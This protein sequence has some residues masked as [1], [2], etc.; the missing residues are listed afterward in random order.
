[1]LNKLTK[2][3]KSFALLLS[4]ELWERW[5]YYGMQALL[6]LYFVKHLGYSDKTAYA[7][8]A[9]F[10]ALLY[11]F[12]S[13]GGF[14]CD[15]LIGAK[16]TL[17]LGASILC[18]GYGF[19]AF[20][21]THE[22]FFPLAVIVVGGGVFKP[23]PSRLIS[24]L[25]EKNSGQ[26]S[27]AFTLFYMSVNVGSLLSMAVTPMVAKYYGFHAAFAVSFVGMFAAV[28]NYIFMRKLLSHIT[29]KAGQR[30]LTL[31]K[32]YI[33]CT[34]LVGSIAISYWLL[35]HYEITG[36]TIL[37]AGIAILIYL[38]KESAHCTT[39][40]KKRLLVAVILVIQAILFFIVYYQMPTTMTL[41][42]LRNTSH[43][44]LG[45]PVSPASFQLLNALWILILS[46]F[47]AMAYNRL[48]KSDSDFSMPSKFAFGTICAGLGILSIPLGILF[49]HHG[50]MN[51]NW[52]ILA[53]GLQSFGELLVSA[54]GLAMIATYM[55]KRM[56]GFAMG[57]WFLCA[58]VG[59]ILSGKIASFTSIPKHIHN[60]ML[61]LPIY[62][63]YFF[64][65]GGITLIV[66]IIMMLFV[67]LLLKLEHETLEVTHFQNVETSV[68]K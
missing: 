14:I 28:V 42:A 34:S 36:Y 32:F 50:L 53:Y 68:E 54:L 17:I 22:I 59:G 58:A 60:P 10:I 66:G 23:N 19:L 26:L 55:P 15:K 12:P 61:S 44:L 8:F 48:N 4:V 20:N 2:D 18:A 29:T 62:Q 49:A 45:I 11:I 41:F 56:M 30:K 51:G 65:M 6:A 39:N 67:P 21:V 37:A 38:F 13:Y 5:A 31:E 57:T 52:L 43:Y 7:I 27:S 46:P 35:H 40:E 1:V 64:M 16:R 9:T 33:V 24:K 47:L 25:Y 3:N 63:H